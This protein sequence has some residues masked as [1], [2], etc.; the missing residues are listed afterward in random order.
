MQAPTLTCWGGGG[1]GEENF[2]HPRKDPR[3]REND[4]KVKRSKRELGSLKGGESGAGKESVGK[5][6][7]SRPCLKGKREG[8]SPLILRQK[9]Q[10]KA[11]KEARVGGGNGDRW[12]GGEGFL[13]RVAI[14]DLRKLNWSDPFQENVHGSV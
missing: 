9:I 6:G 12:E 13:S 2:V 7:K 11:R 10:I 14:A 1:G 5:G 3:G 8:A 4:L